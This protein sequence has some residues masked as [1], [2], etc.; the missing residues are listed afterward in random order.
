MYSQDLYAQIEKLDLSQE[1]DRKSLIGIIDTWSD[2]DVESKNERAAVWAQNIH[3]LIGDQWIRYNDHIHRWETIPYTDANR[4]IDRPVTNH[5]LRWVTVNASGFTSRPSIQVEPNSEEQEDK[6]SSKVAN[7][8]DDYL[9]EKLEKDDHYYELALWALCCGNCFRKGIKKRTRRF[10]KQETESK[11]EIKNYLKEVDC[12][13]VSPFEMAFAGLPKRWRDITI[14]M[15]SQIRNIQWIKDRFDIEAPGYTGEAKEVTKQS[16]YSYT[17]TLG[18]GLRQIVEGQSVLGQSSRR[19]TGQNLDNTAVIKWMYMIPSSKYPKGFMAVIASSKLLYL[20]ASDTFYLDGDIWHPYTSWSFWKQP[21]NIWAASL[22]QQLLPIQRRINAIDA[23]LAYN[24]K[25][26]AVGTWLLPKGSNIPSGTIM[27]VPGQELEYSPDP[28]TGAKPEKIPGTPLPNQVVE[29]RQIL[30]A[31][32]DLIAN[33]ADIR[34]GKN[35]SGVNT[36][37]QL[38]IL[39]EQAE[40]SAS[41]QVETWEKFL[42]R[43]EQIDLLNFQECYQAPDPKTIRKLKSMSKDLTGQDWDQF[44]GAD[45]RENASVRVEPGSTKLLRQRTVL[46]LA[47]AGFLGDVLADPYNQKKFLQEFG[48]GKYYTESNVDVVKAEKAIEMMKGG[49]YLPVLEDV[50]NPDIQIMVLARYMKNPKYMDLPPKIRLLFERRYAE[51]VGMLAK[52][53][54]IPADESQ[55]TAGGKNVNPN[56]GIDKILESRKSP[57]EI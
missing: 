50:D 43:S 4:N 46:R 23:L 40:R 48:L 52:Y 30:L 6:T 35:P 3:Y 25:T 49:I 39:T 10:L 41:K 11:Q 55:V 45:L 9:W 24:R 57:M 12:E 32:G 26:V 44:I 42:E 51:Y 54:T 8:I 14:L 13:I 27:G 47:T 28:V 1:N 20:G 21:G 22:V 16:S 2:D 15:Q 19:Q 33:A 37:G 17:L 36:L 53:P 31:D 7:V 56:E 5:M 38:E 34:S 29:E 18:E